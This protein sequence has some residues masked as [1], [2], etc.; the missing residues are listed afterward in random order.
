MAADDFKSIFQKIM[1]DQDRYS[2]DARAAA[3]MVLVRSHTERCRATIRVSGRLLIEIAALQ[4]EI[5]A[6]QSASSFCSTTRWW[7]AG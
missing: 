3:R 1:A 5:A 7:V 6:L 2:V 4:S